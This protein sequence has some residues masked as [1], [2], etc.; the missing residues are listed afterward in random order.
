MTI[1]TTVSAAAIVAVLVG[2]AVATAAADEC[3][4]MTGAVKG[5]L[6]KTDPA[7]KGGNNPAKLCSAFGEGL[8]VIKS[9][10]IVA[11]ECLEEGDKRTEILAGLD[12]SIRQLQGQLDTNCQ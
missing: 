9:F 3:E 12:R 2:Y 6:D 7:T 11:D 4:A 5:V 1:K 10:G 8:G